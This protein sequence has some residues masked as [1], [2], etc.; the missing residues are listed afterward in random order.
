MAQ[1]RVDAD[2]V[3]DA[4]AAESVTDE[5]WW[6]VVMKDIRR[7]NE[8]HIPSGDVGS[9]VVEWGGGEREQVGQ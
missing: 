6:A 9:S 2:V 7:E 3:G 4:Q 5:S 1:A 8:G